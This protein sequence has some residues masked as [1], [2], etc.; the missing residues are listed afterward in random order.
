[1]DHPVK[2]FFAQMNLVGLEMVQAA[3]L[4]PRFGRK[5]AVAGSI[6]YFTPNIDICAL[7]TPQKRENSPQAISNQKNVTETKN[8]P[9]F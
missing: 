6:K 3:F 9:N 2:I 4:A 7:L 5:V 8:I 1:M